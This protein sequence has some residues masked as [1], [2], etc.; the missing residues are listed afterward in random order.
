MT[1][2]AG[3]PLSVQSMAIAAQDDAAGGQFTA[4]FISA[5]SRHLCAEKLMVMIRLSYC[6]FPRQTGTFGLLPCR[7]GR[8]NRAGGCSG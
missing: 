7:A 3:S 2:V 5:C 8:L 1:C 6:R 4:G